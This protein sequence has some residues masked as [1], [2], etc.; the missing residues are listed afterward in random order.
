MALK[1]LWRRFSTS[2]RDDISRI[3]EE[4]QRQGAIL[5]RQEDLLTQIILRLSPDILKQGSSTHVVEQQMPKAPPASK[6]PRGFLDFER[7]SET[8][9]PVKMR[10]RD[11]AEIARP[12]GHE[13]PQELKRQTARCMDCGTPFCQTNSGCPVNNLIPEWNELVLTDRWKGTLN[14]ELFCSLSGVNTDE[15]PFTLKMRLTDYT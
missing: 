10:I 6:S 1:T 8:Y 4:L 3:T 2:G 12:G 9:R 11:W 7:K 14:F 13:D 15:A 5:K